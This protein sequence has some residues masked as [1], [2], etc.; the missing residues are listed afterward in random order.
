MMDKIVKL[1][2]KT[3]AGVMDAKKALEEAKGDLGQAELIIK[4]KG[5]IKAAKRSER[6][7]SCGRIYS[8]LHQ[9]GKVGAMVELACETDFVA[10][11][12]D[13]ILLC[14]EIAMQVASMNPESVEV[15]LQQDY[16]RDG[17]KKIADLVSESSAKTGE[18][19][20]VVRFV[21]YQLG[22]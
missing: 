8:Y 3:G 11:N 19:T 15:L 17:S 4:E 2:E 18:N 21:R 16:I 20:K 13:F 1:R 7:A 14:K 5:I 22:E 9:T 6:A 12:D 10:K